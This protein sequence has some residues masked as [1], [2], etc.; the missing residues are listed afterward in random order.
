MKLGFVRD[1]ADAVV[2]DPTLITTG[3]GSAVASNPGRFRMPGDLPIERQRRCAASVLL[4]LNRVPPRSSSS[5][6]TNA[7]GG[8]ALGRHSV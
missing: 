5:L 4:A 1:T 6:V 8:L 2:D 7:V 3:L